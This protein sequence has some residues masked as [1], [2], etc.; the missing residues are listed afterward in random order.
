MVVEYCQC[1]DDIPSVAPDL[2]TRLVDLLKVSEIKFSMNSHHQTVI[3]SVQQ[4]SASALYPSPVVR[5][6]GRAHESLWD[7]TGP[8]LIK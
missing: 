2:L 7:F 8:K 4:V 3:T 1:V 5:G 6:M